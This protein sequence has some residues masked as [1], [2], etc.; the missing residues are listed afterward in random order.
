MKTQ[1]VI[2][3]DGPAGAG[4]TTVSRTL[5]DRLGYRYVD[6]GAL[7]R[8]VAYAS[9]LAG[10][11]PDDAAALETLCQGLALR[12]VPSPTGQRLLAG[13]TDVTD[14]IRTP[15]ITM[16][17][18]TVSAQPAV[19]E[20]LLGVQRDMGRQK[21]VVFE[22]RDMGTVVF[23]EAEIKFFLD[24]AIEMRAQRRYLEFQ[25]SNSQKPEEVEKDMRRRDRNDSSRD[26]APLKPAADAVIIDS[27][28]L[29]VEEVIE[30]MLAHINE[31]AGGG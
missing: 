6:T 22:G 8:A 19:R 29:T 16:L 5:A 11:K 9:K 14:N 7:Y 15:E 28:H 25:E 26:L 27:T 21:G 18:S 30:N 24:A 2:T 4:K 23:P 12:F 31:F 13:E 20:Y 1:L 3:I 10:V 17:A